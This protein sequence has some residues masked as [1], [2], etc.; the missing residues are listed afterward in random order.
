LIRRGPRRNFRAK[1]VRI[2]RTEGYY[3]LGIKFDHPIV[4]TKVT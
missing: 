2:T 1:V 4:K 3:F